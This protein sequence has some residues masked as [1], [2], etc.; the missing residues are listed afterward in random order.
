MSMTASDKNRNTIDCE[1][2]SKKAESHIKFLLNFAQV[3]L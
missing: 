3:N 2:S 1:N